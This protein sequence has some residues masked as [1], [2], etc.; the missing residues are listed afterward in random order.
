MATLLIDRAGPARLYRLHFTACHA[1]LRIAG[2]CSTNGRFFHNPSLMTLSVNDG[3]VPGLV[4][5][6]RI[7]TLS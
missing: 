2:E 6:P 1:V 3:F 5:H 4:F 7:A